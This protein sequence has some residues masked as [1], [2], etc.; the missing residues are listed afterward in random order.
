[1][2]RHLECRPHIRFAV[3]SAVDYDKGYLCV[4]IATLRVMLTL[5]RE[6]IDIAIAIHEGPRY[7]IQQLRVYERDNDGREVEPLG[8]R[9][10][11]REMIGAHSGDYFNRAQLIKDLQAVR[12][13][14]RDAGFA[15]VEAEPET[16]LHPVEEQVDIVVPIRRGPPVRVERIEVRATPR[17]RQSDPARNGAAGRAAL[18]RDAPRNGQKA[19]HRARVLRPRRRFDRAGLGAG[20]DDRQYR[21]G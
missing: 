12:T 5:Y 8:G 3:A 13:L 10:A 7:K 21:S 1:L 9:R 15:N 16:E 11:L 19:H 18:Q 6:G 2:D 4:Q 20:Q 14:Y 17:R